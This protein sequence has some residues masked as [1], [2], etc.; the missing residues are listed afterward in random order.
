MTKRRGRYRILTAV[1][2]CNACD[3]NDM[4]NVCFDPMSVALKLLDGCA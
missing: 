4:G 3:V 1:R 2:R